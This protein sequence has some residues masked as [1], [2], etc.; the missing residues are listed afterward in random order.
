MAVWEREEVDTGYLIAKKLKTEL[1][2]FKA[3]NIRNNKRK[4]P[5]KNNYSK[6]I[7]AAEKSI[8]L[9]FIDLTVEQITN[10]PDFH[11]LY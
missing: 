9:S 7:I 1:V 8:S 10:P 5:K 6:I 11:N 3:I 4:V 2:E